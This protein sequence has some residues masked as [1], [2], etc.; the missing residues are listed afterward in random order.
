MQHV[1]KACQYCNFLSGQQNPETKKQQLF[2]MEY[3]EMLLRIDE[4]QLR[5]G[6]YVQL[7]D[8]QLDTP[9]FL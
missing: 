6:V 7:L 8:D 4:E 1:S 9:L 3:E 2:D 5:Y